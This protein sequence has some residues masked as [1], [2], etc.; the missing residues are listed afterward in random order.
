MVMRGGPLVE[1]GDLG[2]RHQTRIIQ[3]LGQSRQIIGMREGFEIRENVQYP[4]VFHDE[5]RSGVVNEELTQL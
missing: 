5:S 1:R 2:G 3:L 4:F